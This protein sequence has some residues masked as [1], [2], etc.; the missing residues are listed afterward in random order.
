MG[1]QI[2][3]DT[4]DNFVGY[5]AHY[6]WDISEK[7]HY[8]DM[9]TSSPTDVLCILHQKRCALLCKKMKMLFCC[10]KYSDISNYML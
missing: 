10:Q 5:D 8:I 7:E 1:Q 9:E 2:L 3:M 4:D 6:L